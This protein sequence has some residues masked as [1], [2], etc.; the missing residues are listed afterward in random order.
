[1]NLCAS[2]PDEAKLRHRI[3]I[4]D[5]DLELS[6]LLGE[7]L[8]EHEF[9]IVCVGNAEHAVLLL[10]SVGHN[11]QALVLDLMLPGMDGLT[12]LKQLRLTTDL[13]ILMMSARGEPIDR[14]I[15]LELGA[16]DYLS[17]PCLP[18]ELLAR[19]QALLRRRNGSEGVNSTASELVLGNLRLLLSQQ[20]VWVANLPLRLTGAEYAVLALLVSQAGKYISRESLTS[21]ALNRPLDRFDRAIDVHVSH[22]RKKM[23]Q[24]SNNAPVIISTR[25]AGYVILKYEEME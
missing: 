18:R 15:G 6:R 13:P 21:G 25:G 1:M 8:S 14:V 23:L 20:R 4:C 12:T 22:L 11:F 19:L 10:E 16:D 17:K 7:Y 5:D 3:L 24:A 9:D 2:K